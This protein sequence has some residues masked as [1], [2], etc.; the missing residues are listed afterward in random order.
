[1][2]SSHS[3]RLPLLKSRFSQPPTPQSEYNAETR[4]LVRAVATVIALILIVSFVSPYLRSTSAPPLT[5]PQSMAATKSAD[6]KGATPTTASA[7]SVTRGKTAFSIGSSNYEL[8]YLTSDA[9]T[10]QPTGGV[11]ILIHGAHR[12]LQNAEYWSKHFQLLNGLSAAPSSPIQR[13]FAMDMLGH[14]L[15]KPVN[16]PPATSFGVFHFGVD[17]AVTLRIERAQ[18]TMRNLLRVCK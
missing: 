8:S 11:M 12:A 9:S 10:A 2:S 17:C 16:A 18:T 4:L 6:S 15:S 5:S 13:W 14:G 7:P 1:M 3:A